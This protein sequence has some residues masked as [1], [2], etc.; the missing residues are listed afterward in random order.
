MHA[1]TTY[2]GSTGSG[3]VRR[4]PVARAEPPAPLTAG[5]TSRYD[6]SSS[7][8]RRHFRWPRCSYR[9]A[10][11]GLRRRDRPRERHT[12]EAGTEAPAQD[13]RLSTGSD[14]TC[15]VKR[16][17]RCAAD[18]GT[19]PAAPTR[20]CDRQ[21][22]SPTST[23][24][25]TTPT[26]AAPASTSTYAATGPA[27]P[28]RTGSGLVRVQ[29]PREHHRDHPHGAPGRLGPLGVRVSSGAMTGPPGRGA[30]CTSP[31]TSSSEVATTVAPGASR[32]VTIRIPGNRSRA[33]ATR[34]SNGPN[35]T[36]M[37]G[38][39]ASIWRARRL[40]PWRPARAP[41]P[42]DTAARFN[43]VSAPRRSPRTAP[44]ARGT[45]LTTTP[46]T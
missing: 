28:A 31:R 22:A 4:R 7:K 37:C 20:P 44:S 16:L 46:S 39:S 9:R 5:V 13:L 8:L 41:T 1:P 24:T 26:A 2:R 34:S 11:D 27:G 12:P 15:Q 29:R 21:I 40:G 23:P 36:R 25:P 42:R 30:P 17:I 3:G 33:S 32:S 38:R 35:A 19:F 18:A 6:I 10:P 14:G 43:A 45:S